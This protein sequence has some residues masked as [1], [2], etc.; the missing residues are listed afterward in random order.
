MREFLI[1]VGAA[2]LAVLLLLAGLWLAGFAPIAGSPTRLGIWLQEATPLLFTGLAAGIAFRAGV[3]NIGLEGQYLL[4][5]VAGVAVLT[6]GAE[7]WAMPWLAAIAGALA[8]AA[9]CAGP[10]ALERS[11]G[12]PLVLSTIL[13]NVVAALVVG[14]LVQGPLH[15]PTTAA[16]QSAVVPDANRWSAVSPDL[17]MHAATP[18]GLILGLIR[19]LLQHPA[20]VLALCLVVIAWLVQRQ[21][22][23]GFE[24]TVVGLNPTAA[25]WAGIPVARREVGAAL[26]SGA[27]AG[28]AGALQVTSVTWFLSSDARSYGY[29]GIAVALLGRLHPLGVIP[30]ALF[31]AGLD[32]GS[33]Q[34]E[35]RM[36]IPHDLGDVA[37]GLAVAIVLIAGALAAGRAARRAGR[38]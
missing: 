16:P 28:V 12:V 17:T 10:V 24:L 3:L 26:V 18:D 21:T 15:D 2:L 23:L 31:F 9:W 4:G 11:R 1:A 33:R 35:R 38:R 25:R 7:G 30:A 37:K 27:C 36:D 20:T 8:G 29:A 22:A 34:L 5:A 13:L 32:L 14:V 19:W 6:C